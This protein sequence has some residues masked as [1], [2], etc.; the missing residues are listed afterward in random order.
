MTS[1]ALI[2]MINYLADD[3]N[4]DDDDDDDKEVMSVANDDS[5]GDDDVSMTFFSRWNLHWDLK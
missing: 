5:G 3:V 2:M 1:I 4:D